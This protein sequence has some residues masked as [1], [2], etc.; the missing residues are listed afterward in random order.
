MKVLGKENNVIIIELDEETI[1]T[2]TECGTPDKDLR[3]Y[4]ENFAMICYDCGCKN[5]ERTRTNFHACL[6]STIIKAEDK[7]N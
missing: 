1:G 6:E 3:P 2:C 4:G 7:V 5:E